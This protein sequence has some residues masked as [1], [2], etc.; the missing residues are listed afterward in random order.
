M[1][2][3]NRSEKIRQGVAASRARGVEWGR[4]GRVLAA[5]NAAEADA[6]AELLRNLVA[7]LIAVGTQTPENIAHR[8]N[9]MGVPTSR[10]GRW[11]RSTIHRLLERLGPSL[12]T[13]VVEAKK[14]GSGL[15]LKWP[16]SMSYFEWR[17]RQG[18]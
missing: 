4:G 12:A 1:T 7:A 17:L 14:S 10:G 9:T 8:F 16:S 2:V 15:A 11:S 5:R 18:D 6:R 3:V 13:N